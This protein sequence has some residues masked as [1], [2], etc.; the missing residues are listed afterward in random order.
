MTNTN[1]IHLFEIAESCENSFNVML[2]DLKNS[3]KNS[4]I[5][6][7]FGLKLNFRRKPNID[8]NL[9]PIEQFKIDKGVEY[10]KKLENLRMNEKNCKKNF[11]IWINKIQEYSAKKYL[12]E[13]NN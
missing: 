7:L 4:G 10:E 5:F 11:N 6:N 3:N 12:S 9:S 2:K 8:A 1:P 13:I